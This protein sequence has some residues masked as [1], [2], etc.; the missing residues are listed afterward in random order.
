M[1][2]AEKLNGPMFHRDRWLNIFLLVQDHVML[3]INVFP[4]TT[5]ESKES[6][7][8]RKRNSSG[9]F[10]VKFSRRFNR[11]FFVRSQITRLSVPLNEY[12]SQNSMQHTKQM[13]NI[14]QK[15]KDF[16]AF[17][18]LMISRLIIWWGIDWSWWSMSTRSTQTTE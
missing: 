10:L 5:N 14:K 2:L 13:N 3:V 11:I 12:L 4:R 8:L 18:H 7:F 1:V 16:L 15:W 9:V 17:I 6:I